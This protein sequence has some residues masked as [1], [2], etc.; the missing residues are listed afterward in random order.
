MRISPDGKNIAYAENDR[1]KYRVMVKSLETGRETTILTDGN[2]V[3]RQ[4]V[5]TSLPLLSWADSH[6]LGVIGTRYGE[7]IFWLYDLTTRSTIPRPLDRFSNTR[8][9]KRGYGWTE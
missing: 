6:T 7:Y 2:K 5:D 8:G 9:N 3:F 4:R 1:G